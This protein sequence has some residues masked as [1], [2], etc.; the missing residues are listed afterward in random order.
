MLILDEWPSR[1]GQSS[2][3]SERSPTDLALP[4]QTLGAQVR[5]QVREF[6]WGFENQTLHSFCSHSPF[7]CF[8]EMCRKS[9]SDAGQPYTVKRQVI[10]VYIFDF[11]LFIIH[12]L[13][14]SRRIC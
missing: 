1:L 5:A 11:F 6:I 10:Q 9:A 8:L 13:S 12:S 7:F 4:F 2:L 14:H 3:P